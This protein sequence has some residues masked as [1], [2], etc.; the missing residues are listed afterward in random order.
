MERY[1]STVP[2]LR[3]LG[4]L[5]LLFLRIMRFFNDVSLDPQRTKIPTILCVH[6]LHGVFKNCE[7][8]AI[9]IAL[10]K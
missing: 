4:N 8:K 9:H 1:R 10:D 7:W 2:M 6:T 3:I 5:R